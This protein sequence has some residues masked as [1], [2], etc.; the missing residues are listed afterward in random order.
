M[1]TNWDLLEHSLNIS[2]ISTKSTLHSS[3]KSCNPNGQNTAAFSPI[4][5][6]RDYHSDSRS[7]CIN[8]IHRPMALSVMPFGIVLPTLVCKGLWGHIT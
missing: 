2:N 4:T 7:M 5:H 6:S 1:K 3:S 8:K